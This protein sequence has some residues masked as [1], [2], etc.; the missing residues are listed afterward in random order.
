MIIRASDACLGDIERVKAIW[1]EARE[2]FGNSGDFLFG[3]FCI[4]DAMYAP[5]M[6]RFLSYGVV[7]DGVERAYVET[8]R[9]LPA[10]ADW[11]ADAATESVAPRHEQDKK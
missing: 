7:L 8:L 3:E 5:V 2:H 11:L 4:A 10:I 6:F 1:R 9:G